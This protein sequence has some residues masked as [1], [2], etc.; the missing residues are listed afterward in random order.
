MRLRTRSR[1]I[2]GRTVGIIGM[3]RIG[4]QV[5][6]RLLPFGTKGLFC[7]PN[8][9]LDNATEKRLN[10]TK[11]DFNTLIA[12]IRYR[13][14]HLPLMASTHNIISAGYII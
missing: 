3:G 14:L 9:T 12:N 8:V 6:E 5:A 13:H 2:M 11:T 10:I 1:E 4:R 7:D